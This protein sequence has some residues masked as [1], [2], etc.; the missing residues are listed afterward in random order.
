MREQKENTEKEWKDKPL[1]GQYTKITENTDKHKTYKWL[2]NGY[3][4]KETE[5]LITAAQDQALPTRWKKVRIEKQPG[6]ALCRMCNEREETTF[7]IL[8]ECSKLAQNEYKKRHDKVAQLVHWNLCKKYEL[9]YAKNWYDHVAE[10][11]TENEKAKILWD[12][13]IQTDHVIQ[14][15]RPDIVVKEKGLDHTWI[16]EI[17]R[18][19]V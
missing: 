9:K 15:R 18:A 13:T 10:S 4:K 6:T 8:S 5:G 19:H 11:V 2:R 14:A 12:F 7:H 1:H 16:I 17:G 3:M